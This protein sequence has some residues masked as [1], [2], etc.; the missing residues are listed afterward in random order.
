MLK[1]NEEEKDRLISKTSE[2][3]KLAGRS[4]DTIENYVYALKRFFRDCT[5]EGK[6]EDFNEDD[7]VNYIKTQ[8]IDKN[9]STNTCNLGIAAIKKMFLVNYRKT[10]INDLIPRAKTTQKLPVIVPKNIFIEI[11]N[12]EENLEH[13]CWLILSYCCGLRACEVATIKIEDICSQNYVEFHIILFMLN[14]QLCGTL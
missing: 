11:F 7:F 1:L 6:L 13:K 9:K 12:N 2:N 4:K 8:L 10:F 5:Y 14:F 3:L